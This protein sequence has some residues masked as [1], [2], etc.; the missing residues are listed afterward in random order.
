LFNSRNTGAGS[1]L[2]FGRNSVIS[3]RC[4]RPAC[5]LITAIRLSVAV[6]SIA[7]GFSST[8]SNRSC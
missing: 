5:S 8:T 4:E 6:P 1:R 7:P 2:A 3:N